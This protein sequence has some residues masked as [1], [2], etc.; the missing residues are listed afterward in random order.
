[1][2]LESFHP[3]P[4]HRAGTW[5]LGN[6]EVGCGVMTNSDGF[7]QLDGASDLF[8]GE[9]S[10]PRFI[11]AT[12]AAR[13]LIMEVTLVLGRLVEV[14]FKS[15]VGRWRCLCHSGALGHLS[16]DPVGLPALPRHSWSVAVA[17]GV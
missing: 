6:G 8:R 16:E 17:G 10:R 15:R 9:A 11:T 13:S 2:V 3:N 12:A 14:A 7:L 5:L 4:Q 1:M